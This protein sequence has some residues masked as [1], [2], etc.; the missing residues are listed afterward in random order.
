[1]RMIAATI[2]AGQDLQDVG[3]HLRGL[4]QVMVLDRVLDAT[5]SE[6]V[7]AFAARHGFD[8]AYVDAAIESA[9][10]NEHFPRMPP[11][12]NRRETAEEFLR[13]AVVVAL[14]D[15]ELHARER[16]W[17]IEAARHNDVDLAVLLDAVEG[18]GGA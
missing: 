11:R 4:V 3:L 1:M 9:L 7:R 14:C 16:E 13:E 18:A 17:L 2:H 12:F 10:D 6:R 5:Q 15:G 8:A